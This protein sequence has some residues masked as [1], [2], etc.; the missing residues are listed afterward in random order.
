MISQHSQLTSLTPEGR[1][2]K[3]VTIKLGEIKNIRNTKINI[4]Q[5]KKFQINTYIL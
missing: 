2:N 4:Y 5:K 3:R 1:K